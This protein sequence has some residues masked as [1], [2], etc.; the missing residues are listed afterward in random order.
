[1]NKKNKNK[2]YNTYNSD[3]INTEDNNI[4]SNKINNSNQETQQQ[5]TDT[6]NTTKSSENIQES[7]P[8]NTKK[9]SGKAKTAI[10]IGAAIIATGIILGS[11]KENKSDDNSNDDIQSKKH[12]QK[13]THEKTNRQIYGNH[14]NI[15]NQKSY[16]E[17]QLLNED[18]AYNITKYRYGNSDIT[19]R[20]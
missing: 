12:K 7:S 1:M 19:R 3:K 13:Q 9:L 11:F 5:K 20:H 4:S 18:I 2:L 15:E 14:I 8:I 10:G 6:N 17:Q 16:Y